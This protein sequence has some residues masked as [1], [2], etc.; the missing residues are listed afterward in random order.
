MQILDLTNLDRST[1]KYKI[2]KFPD[3]Q[4]NITIL[5]MDGNYHNPM[6]GS[7]IFNL[8]KDEITIKSHLN[9]WLDLELIVCAVACLRELEVEKIHLNVPYFVGARS[10]RKF[11]EGGNWYLKQV[12][13]PVI[14]NL[15][16]KSV[17]VLDPH[18]SVLGNLLNNFK[19]INNTNLVNF[20]IDDLWN[21][22]CER[23]DIVLLGRNDFI[24][25]MIWIAPDA[26][27][28]HKIYKIAQK[29]GYKGDIIICSKER[30]TEGK[31][32]ECKCIIPVDKVN[33]DCVIIDDILDGGRTFINI[34]K[35]IQR[36]RSLSSI[37]HPNDYG[38]IYLIVTHGIFSAG[39][40]ELNKYFDGIYCTNS[41]NNIGDFAGNNLEKT[42]VKQLNIY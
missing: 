8:S 11:E 39:F 19:S 14:N 42:N 26:G 17:T 21:Q 7:G 36:H 18:S 31:L 28:S 6:E 34:A 2:S 41:Y 22:H 5:N 40:E 27:A 16:F 37:V 32:T 15:N 1:I 24:N 12:I 25:D 10:D 9:N 13:C 30:D 38:K 23:K 3:G 29:I 20:F 35:V 33:K 4:Q